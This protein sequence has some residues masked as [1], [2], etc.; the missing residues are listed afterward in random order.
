[1]IIGCAITTFPLLFIYNFNSN[2]LKVN[3]K[4]IVVMYKNQT[5]T[6]S[7]IICI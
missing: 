1:M 6:S 4:A 7:Y 5:K 2:K 3:L